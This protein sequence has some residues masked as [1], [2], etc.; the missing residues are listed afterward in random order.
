MTMLS[1]YNN[2]KINHIFNYYMGIYTNGI[3]YG[4]QIYKVDDDY[5]IHT[6][7]TQKYETIM[8]D[9]QLREAYSFYTEL[10]DKNKLLF[11]IYTECSST[12][13]K[14]NRDNYMAWHPISLDKFLEKFS[15]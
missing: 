7:F 13:D 8:S 12:L 1:H 2:I 5:N 11:R 3:I 14:Y 4:I 6:I 9:E 15:S 10:D